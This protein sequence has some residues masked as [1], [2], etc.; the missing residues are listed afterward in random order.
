MKER[1]KERSIEKKKKS[2][3]YREREIEKSTIDKFIKNYLTN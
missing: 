1:K 2:I 3:Q